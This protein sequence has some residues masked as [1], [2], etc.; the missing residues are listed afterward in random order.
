MVQGQEQ[1]CLL[2]RLLCSEGEFTLSY[3]KVLFSWLGNEDM[4]TSTDPMVDDLREAVLYALRKEEAKGLAMIVMRSCRKNGFLSFLQHFQINVND[5]IPP[6]DQTDE[7]YDYQPKI[8]HLLYLFSSIHMNVFQ[9]LVQ[10]CSLNINAV[11]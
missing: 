3:A 7:S 9:A 11:Y 10:Q 4:C 1:C 2:F 8:H 5:L 6:P